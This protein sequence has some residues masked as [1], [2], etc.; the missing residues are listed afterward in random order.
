VTKT[1]K[2]HGNGVN[3]STWTVWTLHL[4]VYQDFDGT[5]KSPP[6]STSYTLT[7]QFIRGVIRGCP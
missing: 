1:E 6:F 7:V 2:G 3:V 5:A 4:Q